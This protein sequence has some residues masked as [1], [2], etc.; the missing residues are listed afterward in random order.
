MCPIPASTAAVSSAVGL[1]HPAEDDPV[2]R[3]AGGE[4]PGQL[5]AGDDVGAGAE[6]AQDPE[7]GEVA[8]SP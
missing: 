7:H 4:R 5:A 1:P 2:R 6:I 3:E 8:R